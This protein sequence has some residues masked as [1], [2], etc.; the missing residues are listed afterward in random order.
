MKRFPESA[1]C[2]I[3]LS[4]APSQNPITFVHQSLIGSFVADRYT[5][6]IYDVQFNTI[7]QITNSFLRDILL[8]MSLLNELDEMQEVV[9]TRYLGDSRKAI[10][11]IIRDAASKLRER[12]KQD[13]TT[14]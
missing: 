14:A 3:G 2:V 13:E 11:V 5:G 4:K 1:V 7:C 12:C 9:R 6:E 10:A 8:G